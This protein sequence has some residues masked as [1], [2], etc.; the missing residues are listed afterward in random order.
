MST[1]AKSASSCPPSRLCVRAQLLSPTRMESCSSWANRNP[2]ILEAK[3]LCSHPFSDLNAENVR[4]CDVMLGRTIPKRGGFWEPYQSRVPV[5]GETPSQV[6]S[7]A[8]QKRI[9][10][11]LRCYSNS[12]QQI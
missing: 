8:I 1:K 9:R 11:A 3:R 5:E 6:P 12:C 10:Y 7:V 2:R 4:A